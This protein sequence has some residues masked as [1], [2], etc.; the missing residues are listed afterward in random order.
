AN[1]G[2]HTDHFDT[3]F[4]VTDIGFLRT[5]T[6]RNRFD[7][8]IEVGQPDP[9]THLRQYWFGFNSGQSWN[10]ERLVFDR[11]AETYFAFQFLNYW[12]GHFG[13]GRDFERMDDRDTRGG[14]P[15]VV[16]SAYYTFWHVES[17]SRKSWKWTANYSRWI[18]RVGGHADNYETGVSMQPS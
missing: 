12:R 14:P 13:A 10:D 2:L 4:R 7:G 15:I 3:N 16:P 17:D 8:S 6:N 9:G 1:G 18:S 5:R 11:N